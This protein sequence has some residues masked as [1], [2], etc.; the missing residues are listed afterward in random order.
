M[1]RGTA[2]LPELLERVSPVRVHCGEGM[3][4]ELG[5]AACEIGLRHVLLVSDPGIV[6]AGH[7]DR[8]ESLLAEAGVRVTRFTG[9]Y[10]NPDTRVVD[11]GVAVARDASIDGFIGLGGGSAMDAA[12][13]VD[14]LLTNGGRVADYWGV[15]KTHAPTLP[16]IAVPTTAGTGSEA[17]SFALISDAETHAKMACGDRRLPSDGGLRPHVAILDSD[18]TATQPRTVAA[19]TALDAISHAV[20]SA[21]CN[22]RTDASREL[23]REAWARLSASFA[24]A[25]QA[26]NDEAARLAMLIGAHLAG[27]AIE[28]AMLGAAHA[29][30]NPLTARY[31]ITHGVA[32]GVM[33]PHV[34]RFNAA[35]ENPYDD[36]VADAMELSKQLSGFLALAGMPRSLRELDVPKADLDELA[37][38]ATTQW[39]ARFNPRAVA[40]SDLLAVYR[41]AYG[42]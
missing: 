38:L 8:A 28:T 7:V 41:D 14:L 27:A 34:V 17:Q 36:L 2:E 22:A 11:A 5:S 13:G 40:A 9:I 42:A 18:L 30:A 12:K 19:A 31:G 32:V 15:D 1:T 26:P 4:D 24:T 37:E 29:C 21:G 39:T 20:E 10:E 3:L 25:L 16:M 6:A 33:L 35:D 23:S